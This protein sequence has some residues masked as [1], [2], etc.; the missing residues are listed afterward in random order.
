[1][2]IRTRQEEIAEILRTARVVAVLGASP[3][4]HR[5][6]H[7]VPQYLDQQGYEVHAVN[8]EVAGRALFG[9]AAVARLQDVT[10]PVDVVDV[11]RR[12]SHLPDHLDD[13]LGMRPR[14]KAVWL[15]SGIRHDAFASSLDAAGIDVVQD[16]CMLVDHQRFL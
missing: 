14:P 9:R 13:I 2:P 16:R 11:F 6:G 1:M 7:Y 15:Q 5:A 3:E 12:S 10:A 8:P 4:P